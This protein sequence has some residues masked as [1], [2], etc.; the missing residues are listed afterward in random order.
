[1]IAALLIGKEH[2]RELPD[3]NLLGIDGKCMMEYPLD[4]ALESAEVDRVFVSTDSQEI[5]RIA[6]EHG[7]SVIYRPAYLAT[8]KA[9]AIDVIRHGYQFLRANLGLNI[10]LLVFLHCNSPCVTAETIDRGINLMRANPDADSC[11][12]YSRYNEY[13]PGRAMRID[14]GHVTAF[15]PMMAITTTS[16]RD[17][18]GD[19]YFYDGGLAVIRS[20][21]VESRHYGFQPYPWLGRVRIPIVQEGGLDVDNIRGLVQAQWWIR[22]FYFK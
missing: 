9:L 22:K 14:N 12:T 5:A 16:D 6:I 3:K 8:D 21:C 7:A 13:N 2:S 20:H 4:A 1:M 18:A 19:V 10:E 15:N 17:S 11:A